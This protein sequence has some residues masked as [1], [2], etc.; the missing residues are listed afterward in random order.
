MLHDITELRRL[1]NLRQEF[2][3]NVSHELKTPLASVK[4]FAET[5]RLGAVHDPENNVR[6]VQRIEEQAER[7]HQL[8]QDMLQIARIESGEQAFDITTVLVDHVVEI[9]ASQHGEAARRKDIQIVVQPPGSMLNVRADEEGLR[10]ILDNLISN[11]IKYTPK[12]GSVRVSWRRD[13]G[14]V[15][16]EVA[17]TG[18]GIAYEDQARIF[19]RFF[20]S[21]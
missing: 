11:G 13:Q 10:T 21:G 2:V 19:E 15:I 14:E 4:A 17:D 18:I 16:L 6:F 9:C 20:P 12:G 5:L 7:L 3:A 8:I 1:E